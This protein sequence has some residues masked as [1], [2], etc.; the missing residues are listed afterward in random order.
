MLL[1]LAATLA[2]GAALGLLLSKLRVPGGFM[3]GS[4][5]G[6]AAF[7]I[8]FQCAWVPIQ[9]SAL[10]QIVSGAFIGC[11][12]ERSDLV[13]LPHILKP[14]LIM[15]ASLMVLML[16]CGFAIWS[17]S[18][19]DLVT[20]LM[21]VVPG[22]ISDTPIVAADMGADGAKVALLQMVRQVLGL[23]ILPNAIYLWGKYVIK[24]EAENEDANKAKRLK[25]KHASWTGLLMTFA[26]AGTAGMIGRTLGIPAGTFVFA[27]VSTLIFKLTT[28]RAYLPS[29]LKRC[30]QILSGCSL[31][32][33]VTMAS[34]YT[35]TDLCLP[36][37]IIA[38]AYTL[39]AFLTG[40][41]ISRFCG[42]TKKEG[43]LIC[44]PAG[45]SDMALI[46]AEIGILNT[47]VVILQV[48]RAVTVMALFP[49]VVALMVHLFG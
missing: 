34:V 6:S 22:G 29:P 13:R 41:I 43:M 23:A 5:F 42:F 48:V 32:S 8:A 16:G 9:L 12:M 15:L 39:N 40:Y 18:S 24:V 17:V 28:D 19:L 30:A 44:T 35:L 47:D 33:T 14:A 45:A 31:G 49:Q 11:S 20:A 2:A 46:S 37:G 3:I 21:S 4:L 1:N 10:V 38:A 26:I 27:L 25:S 7:N 36:V